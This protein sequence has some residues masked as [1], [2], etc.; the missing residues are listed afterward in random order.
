MEKYRKRIQVVYDSILEVEEKSSLGMRHEISQARLRDFENLLLAMFALNI[1]NALK[2]YNN[3]FLEGIFNKI[4]EEFE[5]DYKD[6]VKRRFRSRSIFNSRM[7]ELIES[8]DRVKDRLLKEILKE[9]KMT[10]T[11]TKT[12]YGI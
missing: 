8:Q 3:N 10:L 7:D 4:I 9:V 12:N 1:L 2:E 6:L 11:K 5:N